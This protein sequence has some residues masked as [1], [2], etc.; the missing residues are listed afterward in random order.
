M[1]GKTFD[2][3]VR[4][5]AQPPSITRKIDTG[6]AKSYVLRRMNLAET[7]EMT[8]L[9]LAIIFLLL[10]LVNLRTRP[11]FKSKRDKCYQES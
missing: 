5:N 3:K 6:C 9:S 2:A 10:I 7:I 1:I 4:A 8:R 11:R